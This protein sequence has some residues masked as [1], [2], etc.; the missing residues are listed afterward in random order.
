MPRLFLFPAVLAFAALSGPAAAQRATEP[1]ECGGTHVIARGD[2]LQ[3]LAVRAYGPDAS[4]RT[5][6][7][8]NRER[9]RLRDPSL[10]EVGQEI[11]IPC[12]DESG[13][14]LAAPDPAVTAGAEPATAPVMDAPAPQVGRPADG[15]GAGDGV[16]EDAAPDSRSQEAFSEAQPVAAPPEAGPPVLTV[17]EGAELGAAL[18]AEA[19]AAVTTDSPSPPLLVALAPAGGCVGAHDCAGLAWSD[20]IV[21]ALA[22]AHTRRD[23]EWLTGLEGLRVC[24]AADLPPSLAEDAGAVIERPS[25]AACLRLVAI[26]EADASLT[27]AAAADAAL[28]DRLLAATLVEQHAL[29]RLIDVRAAADPE[30]PRA[31]AA[32]Q[33]LDTALDRM[34]EGG[35]WF[36]AVSAQLT[37]GAD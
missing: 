27:P 31:V 4:F 37:N 16:A 7:L 23:R 29:A 1:L 10:I 21:Q 20:P 14:P 11:E 30:D 17:A 8:H 28:R 6:W 26:G 2:T 33:T 32:L 15:A 36:E 3:R 9:L 35:G 22:V 24:R 19:L 12:L 18:A 5:L 13:A 25:A 34:R